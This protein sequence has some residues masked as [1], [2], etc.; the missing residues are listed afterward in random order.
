V[1]AFTGHAV[2]LIR[3]SSPYQIAV[4][5]GAI[6]WQLPCLADSIQCL[7]NTLVGYPIADPQAAPS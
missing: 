5:A 2:C 7:A 6:V 1:V 4:S 3:V